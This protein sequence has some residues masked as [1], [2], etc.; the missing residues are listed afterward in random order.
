MTEKGQLNTKKKYTPIYLYGAI[1]ILEGIS[2]LFS[3]N[4][5]FRTIQLSLGITLTS[6]AI[7]AFM[8]A[9]SRQRKQVQFAYHE[10][11]ALAMMA[12]GL[13]ILLFCDTREKLISFTTFL[14][15]FYAFSEIIFCNWLF[16]LAQSTV[17]KIVLVRVVIGLA[18][19]IGT[20][21]AIT[22]L[23]FTLE[24]FGAL[25]IMI[26]INIMLYVPIM[27]GSQFN[28]PTKELPL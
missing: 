9:L 18:V 2:L 22:Y 23:D 6:G 5:D 19:G 25:F 4:S 8:A 17:L 3:K 16:N 10:L 26:G 12:Y 27:K 1:I 15:I 28:Q 14:F 7:L 21:F 11:H 20:V 24:I 13:S